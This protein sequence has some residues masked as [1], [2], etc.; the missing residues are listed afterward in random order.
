LCTA[1]A[2]RLD[3]HAHIVKIST[4]PQAFRTRQDDAIAVTNGL[5]ARTCHN[6]CEKMESF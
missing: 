3:C 5:N 6:F 2:D 4:E 1:R